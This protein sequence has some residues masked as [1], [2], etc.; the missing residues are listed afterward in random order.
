MTPNLSFDHGR[1]LGLCGN[2]ISVAEISAH[3]DVYLG[4]ARVLVGDLRDGGLVE[5]TGGVVGD[6]GPDLHTLE[7][8]LH[9]LQTF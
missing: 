5:V 9:D 1:A 8:L 7:R 6:E 4:V 3:L 2:P